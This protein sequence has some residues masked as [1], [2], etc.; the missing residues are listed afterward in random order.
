VRREDTDGDLGY[1]GEG[2]HSPQLGV[3]KGEGRMEEPAHVE[4]SARIVSS[5]AAAAEARL[6]RAGEAILTEV[7]APPPVVGEVAAGEVTAADVSSDPLGQED[8]REVTVKTT[9]ETS[10][11]VEASES[12]ELAAPSA[13]TIMSTFG[14][15]IGMAAGPLLF[16]AASDSGKAPQGPLTARAAGSERGEAS[17]APDAA[18]KG[19]SGEKIHVATA[20]S[21]AGSLSSASQLQ[22]EWADTA[23]SIETSGK[24]KA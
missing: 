21:S 22:Q 6:T 9:G 18:A 7:I 17:P 5:P 2:H 16:G 13:Q 10:A 24:L 12:P 3:V 20:G 8:T 4:T 23:S 14:M 15:G 19:A 1:A 11:R